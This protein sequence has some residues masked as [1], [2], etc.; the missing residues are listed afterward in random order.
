L[1]VA[2][3]LLVFAPTPVFLLPGVLAVLTLLAALGLHLFAQAPFLITSV[4]A[5][6]VHHGSNY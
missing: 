2:V 6:N 1:P 4:A 3:F 5:E